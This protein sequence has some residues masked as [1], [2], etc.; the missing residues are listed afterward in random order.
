[1][2]GHM[3]ADQRMKH[4][5]IVNGVYGSLQVQVIEIQQLRDHDVSLQCLEK[6][7]AKKSL[8]NVERKNFRVVLMQAGVSWI[9]CNIA[10]SS[11]ESPREFADDCCVVMPI[12]SAFRKKDD[13]SLIARESLERSILLPVRDKTADAAQCFA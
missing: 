2:I 4:V 10:D 6:H 9:G 8:P 13:S 3:R 12:L 11:A 5:D 7:D 1:M